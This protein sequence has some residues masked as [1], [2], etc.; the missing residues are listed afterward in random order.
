MQ[1]DFQG[2]AMKKIF[3]IYVFFSALLFV[4]SCG[5]GSNK[6]D[7]TDSGETV[8]DGDTADT[9]PAGDLEPSDTTPDDGDSVDTTPDSGDSTDSM[10]D[11]EVVTTPCNPNPC[12]ILSASTGKCTE[13]EETYECEC[14]ENYVWKDGDCVG[15]T[16]KV[17]CE[18]LPENAEWI[19]ATE[20]T[21]TWNGSIWE[22]STVGV[23]N[24]E[25]ADNEC[26][27]KCEGKYEWDGAKCTVVIPPCSAENADKTCK[28]YETG[29]IWSVKSD[30][31]YTYRNQKAE[32]YCKELTTDGLSWKLPD[33]D[34]LRTIIRNCDKTK[35]NGT[36]QVSEE[37]W[38]DETYWSEETCGGCELNEAEGNSIFGDKSKGFWS[39]T[40]SN[41]STRYA[42]IVAFWAS[43]YAQVTSTK[44]DSEMLVRCLG[45]GKCKENFEVDGNFE[46]VPAS[47]QVKCEGLPENAINNPAGHN[48]YQTWNEESGKWLPGTQYQYCSSY[49][50]SRC[51]FQCKSGFEWNSSTKKCERRTRTVK[52]QGLPDNAGWNT[53]DEITQEQHNGEWIP[54]YVG[55]YSEEPSM[56]E[57]RFKCKE[58]Y[59]PDR[60]DLVNYKINKCQK[61][62]CGNLVYSDHSC[63]DS[64]SGLTWSP[65]LS[66]RTTYLPDAVEYCKNMV[67]GGYHDWRL[68]TIDE[69]RTLIINCE[70]TVTGGICPISDPDH[71][72]SGEENWME[73]CMCDKS[74]G[75]SSQK[76]S[77]LGDSVKLWSSSAVSDYD[78]VPANWS[79]NFKNGNIYFLGS[80]ENALPVRCVR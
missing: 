44:Q 5:G 45:S 2:N 70:K 65:V 38:S 12:W 48:I 33:I 67:W 26:R 31:T 79:V 18:D 73:N 41:L 32:L 74:G 23:Y 72:S 9:E 6:D 64:V 53:V 50:S 17:K 49:D 80:E 58:L 75:D 69:L 68:P 11:D 39:S 8:T 78:G 10:P 7:K 1:F 25:A 14:S 66:F 56:T 29:Y 35:I 63:K 54:S 24:E 77:K 13:K 20:V 22:P 3:V 55:V 71:L 28:D 16:Q 19:G 60:H 27:F 62:E 47:R 46:C 59:E 61:V 52:C 42:W 30:G 76:H 15:D 43:G 57:C 21:Q 34:E 36:C 51:C 40:A 37:N 4:V